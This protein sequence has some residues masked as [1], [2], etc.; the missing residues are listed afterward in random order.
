[1]SCVKSGGDQDAAGLGLFAVPGSPVA[2]LAHVGGVVPCDGVP[3]D[4]EGPAGELEGDGAADHAG[5]AAAGL[6]GAEDLLRDLY[7]PPAGVACDDGG[8]AGRRVGGDQGQ[9]IADGAAVADQDH[10]DV[11]G[12]EDGVPQAGQRGGL[13]GDGRAIAGDV[14]R[15]ERRRGGE[16]CQGREP[17]PADAGPAAHAGAPRRQLVQ[18]VLAQP[19]GPGDPGRELPDFFS[20][21]G[22][23]GDNM[24]GAA[25]QRA[26]QGFGHPAGQPQ[27]RRRPGVLDHQLSEHRQRHGAGA[28]RKVGHDRGDD[29][30]VAAPG[31]MPVL[32]RAVVEPGR[33]PDLLP[34]PPE[35]GVI[36]RDG[37]RLPGRHQ[38]RHHQPGHHQPGHRQAQVTGIPAGPGEE[39]MH[40]VMTPLATGPPRSAS[41]TPSASRYAPRARRPASRSYGT[42]GQ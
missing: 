37:H 14:D 20:R 40:P 19:G 17:V 23:V 36:D 15:G 24:D 18:G 11:A 42:T 30:V 34:A 38:Q 2:V 9:V 32:H 35:Q 16:P 31:L 12:T 13:H 21:V 6:P 22:G 3:G 5:E 33:G 41:R 7:G 25:G 28:E 27:P 8:G 29:P 1:V 4:G 10:L 39:L 26:G